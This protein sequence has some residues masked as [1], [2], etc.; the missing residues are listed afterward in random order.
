MN[1]KR[2]FLVIVAV[3]SMAV[4]FGVNAY[5]GWYTCSVEMAGPGGGTTIYVNL[6]HSAF[7]NRW[8]IAS[9]EKQN[10][11]LATALAAM[12][13][14]TRVYVYLGSTDALSYIQ[15]MYMTTYS[16][17]GSAMDDVQFPEITDMPQ[18]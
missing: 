18:P 13:N 10:E 4:F 8:F 17:T 7:S 5:A 15:A 9:S 14:N 12:S 3:V 6:S 16:A 1:V 11:I 2:M